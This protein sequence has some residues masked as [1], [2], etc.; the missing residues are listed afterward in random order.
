M[1]HRARITV[2]VRGRGVTTRPGRAG[3]PVAA[4]LGALVG[5]LVVLATCPSTAAPQAAAPPIHTAAM[6]A[7]GELRV[8][9]DGPSAGYDRDAFGDGWAGTEPGCDTRD[10]V[11]A[12][13][14]TATTSRGCDVLTGTLADPYTGQRVTGPTRALDVDHVVALALAWRTGAAGWTPAAREAFANDPAN[15]LAT[16]AATNRAKGSAGPEQWLPPVDRCG[17]ATRFRGVV[18]RYGLSVTAA[19]RDALAGACR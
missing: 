5:V 2:R 9:P 18:E 3:R 7:A 14:L 12:R 17:Y 8:A 16:T 4:L 11:L 6:A 15:L 10:T 19:R 1:S 13:D